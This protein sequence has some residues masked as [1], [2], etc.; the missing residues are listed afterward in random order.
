MLK[1]TALHELHKKRDAKRAPF[2]GFDL[3]LYYPSGAL[4]E[5]LLCREVAAVFDV[6]HMGQ[7]EVS[8]VDGAVQTVLTDLETLIPSDLTGLAS[9][10]QRYGLL[11][12][13]DGG[14][15]DDLMVMNLG[16]HVRLVVNAACVEKDIDWLHRHLGHLDIQLLSRSLVALQGPAAESALSGLVQGAGDLAFM[17]AGSFTFDGQTVQISRSGYTGE[18]GFEVSLPD[19]IAAHFA[20]ALC[21]TGQADMA[22]LVA[23][24]SLRLE[25]G[26][27]LYGQDMDED[28]SV[29]DA[30]LG[31]AV[32]RARRA[33]GARSGGFFGAER[34]LRELQSG[35]EHS[36]IGAAS[37]SKVPVRAGAAVYASEQAT[38]SI[39]HVTSGSPAPSA[40]HPVVMMRLLA[41]QQLSAGDNVWADVRGRRIALTICAM[42]FFPHRFKR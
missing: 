4:K 26:L 14:I 27:C 21:A 25:A 23:R 7:I 13:K 33:G 3:P 40:G 18:D 34:T 16:S 6:S 20:E 9:G 37:L 1:T 5:H 29:A 36:R 17:Q 8:A 24:D 30:S 31:W 19:E 12:N 41:T 28:T 22:G 10:Q 35:A 39:G 2:A 38:A 32:G 11:L 42:P 15:I